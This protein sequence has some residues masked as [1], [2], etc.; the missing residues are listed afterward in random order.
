[1]IALIE[2]DFVAI[3]TLRSIP[4]DEACPTVIL[5]TPAAE[6]RRVHEWTAGTHP[7]FES[8]CQVQR[9]LVNLAQQGECR[10]QGPF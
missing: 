9:G 5:L 2:T 6:S 1:M 7:G 8:V 4:P 10:Y 3:I